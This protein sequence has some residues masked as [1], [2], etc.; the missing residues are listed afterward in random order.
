MKLKQAYDVFKASH[1]D[2]LLKL[3]C[4]IY[5]NQKFYF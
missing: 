3:V 4:P 5:T 1:N 2:M